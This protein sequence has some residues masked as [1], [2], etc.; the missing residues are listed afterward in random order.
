MRKIEGEWVIKDIAFIDDWSHEEYVE[1][2]SY[3]KNLI[4]TGGYAVGVFLERKIE[5]FL[6]LLSRLYSVRT[7]SIW[8]CRI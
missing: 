2:V 5:R 3:L 1:G 4:L 6:C 7:V 8:I